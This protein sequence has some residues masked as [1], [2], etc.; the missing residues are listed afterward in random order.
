LGGGETAVSLLQRAY[1]FQQ[2]LFSFAQQ[3]II[4]PGRQVSVGM[5]GGVRAAEND[6]A[7][8]GLGHFGHGESGLAHI[9]QAHF[10]KVVEVILIDNGVARLTLG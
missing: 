3:H 9:Q 6:A 8:L 5:V 4:R 10:G 7:A 1:Q 2:R